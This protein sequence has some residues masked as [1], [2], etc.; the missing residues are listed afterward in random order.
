MRL[1]IERETIDRDPHRRLDLRLLSLC[2]HFSA[3]QPPRDTES[4]SSE[5]H[6]PSSRSRRGR[7]EV[8][9]ASCHFISRTTEGIASSGGTPV[10]EW[11]VHGLQL[12][13]ALAALRFS[14]RTKLPVPRLADAQHSI[15]A[16]PNG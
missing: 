11:A 3:T 1:Q 5:T 15:I 6:T 14:P 4:E 13:V 10:Q 7:S 12:P 2:S 8:L 9:D 16:K